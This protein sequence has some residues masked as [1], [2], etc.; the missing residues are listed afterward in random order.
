MAIIRTAAFLL[1]VV[2][3]LPAAAAPDAVLWPR[4]QTFDAAST[5]T[6][7]HSA[8]DR[9]LAAHVSPDRDGVNR[10]AYGRIDDA[11]K[12]ALAAYLAHLQSVPVSRLARPEQ[13]A[14]WIN[15]Y[16][17]LTVKVVLDHYP[18]ESI[19]KIGIS[20][21]FFSTGPW[22][23]RLATVEGER[24]SLDDIEHRILR[25]IWKDPRI[26]YAVN[27]ASVGCPNLRREAYA[28]RRIEAQLDG[29]ARAYVNNWRG[30]SF[31]G[32]AVY[33]SS[34]YK[35]YVADF[36][37]DEAGVLAHLRRY[38]DRGLADRLAHTAKIASYQYDWA[39]NDLTR[40][41]MAE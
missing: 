32:A 23:A 31:D 2:L 36:G 6:V 3:A 5:A 20:P 4:W 35:W 41:R 16:N 26:H 29:Q 1:M 13:M 22:G 7:D 10:I 11:Q 40:P 19:L 30:A 17:A 15:L 28:G 25:P 21:G 24:L 38:A 34:I 8:W 14:F 39:L 37:G 12:A 27:C 9:W 18:V 33:V